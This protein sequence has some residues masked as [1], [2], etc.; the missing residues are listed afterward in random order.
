MII[1]LYTGNQWNVLKAIAKE[2]KAQN[3]YSKA[4]LKKYN[5]YNPS[6]VK[7]SVDSLIKDQLIYKTIVKGVTQYEIQDI[8]LGK[9]L[10]R[11]PS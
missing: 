11:L 5:F 1:P 2:E 8:F 3:I 4:F 10:A 6:S 9:W 7:K